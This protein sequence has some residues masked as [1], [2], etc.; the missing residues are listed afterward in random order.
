MK[1]KYI[2]KLQEKHMNHWLNL[3]IRWPGT[4]ITGYCLMLSLQYA[5]DIPIPVPLLTMSCCIQSVNALYFAQRVAKNYGVSQYRHDQALNEG[6]AS[7]K[8]SQ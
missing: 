1:D 6:K 8:K 2:T 4:V 7:A 3:G 5:K